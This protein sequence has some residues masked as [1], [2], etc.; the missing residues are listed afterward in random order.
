MSNVVRL[1]VGLLLAS[2]SFF[3]SPHDAQA[4]TGPQTGSW[5]ISFGGPN[6]GLTLSYDSGWVELRGR[7]DSYVCSMQSSGT[8]EGSWSSAAGNHGSFRM[9]FHSDF[10]NGYTIVDGYWWY[11]G[12]SYADGRA[13]NGTFRY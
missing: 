11:D 5:E 1:A 4:Q 9:T 2:A 7:G 6:N 3:L 10:G 8:C 13:L 12:E